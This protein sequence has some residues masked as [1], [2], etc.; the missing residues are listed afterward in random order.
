MQIE[1]I[2]REYAY[3]VWDNCGISYSVI[4]I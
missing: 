1:R 2:Q 4:K 3:E